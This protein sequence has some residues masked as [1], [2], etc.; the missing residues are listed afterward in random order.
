M[1]EG[2]NRV[3]ATPSNKP[4]SIGEPDTGR[5]PEPCCTRE[6]KVKHLPR[7]CLKVCANIV[8]GSF[9]CQPTL[10]HLDGAATAYIGPEGSNSG[11]TRRQ[12][13]LLHPHNHYR[14]ST[15]NRW[16][17]PILKRITN[18]HRWRIIYRSTQGC[19]LYACWLYKIHR[20]TEFSAIL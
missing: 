13:G 3:R 1:P 15:A 6:K 12:A 19:Q 10:R 2:E 20:Y 18:T 4:T 8:R 17:D 9:K 11:Q 7:R 14:R 16:R 5:L